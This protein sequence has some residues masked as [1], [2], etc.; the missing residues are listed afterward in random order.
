MPVV[1]AT[2][3]AEAELLEPRRWRLRLGNKSETLSQKKKRERKESTEAAWKHEDGAHFGKPRWEDHLKSEIQ[4]QTGQY[5]ETPSLL[6]IQKL[7][8]HGDAKSLK[9]KVCASAILCT[10]TE[11]IFTNMVFILAE[12]LNFASLM[13]ECSG[14]ILA[15]YNLHLPSS[16]D[17]PASVSQVAGIIGSYHHAQPIFV[18]LVE[19]GFHH[20]GLSHDMAATYPRENDPTESKRK[21][22][23]SLALSPRLEYSYMIL[24]NC[25]LCFPGSRTGFHHV[26]QAR[27]P[28]LKT[29]K[30]GKEKEKV[31]K[32]EK[33]VKKEK[34]E[35]EVTEEEEEKEKREE[36]EKKK[37]MS[38]RQQ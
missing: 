26:G 30:R 32:K 20:V 29:R 12:F 36:E 10:D 27:T 23:K 37:R 2:Q 24:A 3:E 25:N 22:A 38:K 35:E 1:P 15:H 28:D 7:A 4:D 8:R 31:E 6:K 5:G 9:N 21:C 13:L 33:E 14:A 16:S 18:F 19:T 34:K 11:Y 17:S